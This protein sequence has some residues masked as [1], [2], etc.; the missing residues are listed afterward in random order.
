MT[1]PVGGASEAALSLVE[2]VKATAVAAIARPKQPSEWELV[3]RVEDECGV[4]ARW[5]I[6]QALKA[7]GLL[8]RMAQQMLPPR[9][10][11]KPRGTRR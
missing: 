9:P 10:V 2:L 1:E 8:E 11:R 5:L 7:A 3:Q 4:R 6:R